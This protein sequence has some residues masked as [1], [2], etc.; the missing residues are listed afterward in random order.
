M[1]L[2]AAAELYVYYKVSSAQ[3][4]AALQAFDACLAGLTGPRPRLMARDELASGLQTWM[5]IHAGAESAELEQKLAAALAPFI[6]GSR[7]VE[8]FGPLR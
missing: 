1:S 8:R 3:A 7:H 4:G 2:P 6:S 5:E